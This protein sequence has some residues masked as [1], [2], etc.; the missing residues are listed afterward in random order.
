[1]LS[2]LHH[3]PQGNIQYYTHKRATVHSHA[4]N[5]SFARYLTK[6]YTTTQLTLT[7]YRCTPSQ[8]AQQSAQLGERPYTCE[9]ISHTREMASTQVYQMS[10]IISKHFARTFSRISHHTTLLLYWKQ[11][12]QHSSVHL[13]HK[14]V[15]H[16]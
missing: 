13:Y 1:M 11:A 14:E 7:P 2:T 8:V 3:P 12:A 4:L 15:Q 6:S 10:F 16:V 5:T 9:A